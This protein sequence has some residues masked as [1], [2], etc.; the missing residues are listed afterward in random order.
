[1][2]PCLYVG[3]SQGSRMSDIPGPIGTVIEGSYLD[4]L[5]PGLLASDFKFSKFQNSFCRQ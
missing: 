3:S 5:V 1:M 4:Y 2:K